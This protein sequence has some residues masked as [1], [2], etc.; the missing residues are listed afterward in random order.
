MQ[1]T[2]GMTEVLSA[3]QPIEAPALLRCGIDLNVASADEICA[4]IDGVGR[5]LG[6]AIVRDREIFGPFLTLRDLARVQGVGPR[7]FTRITGLAWRADG[8]AQREK[9]LEI[10]SPS[11]DGDIDLP[12]VARRF[13]SMKGFAGCLISDPDGHIVACSWADEK[14]EAL[15]AVAPHFIKKI[16]K[17]LPLIGAGEIDAMTIFV[18]ERALTMIP[19]AHLVMVL[20]QDANQFS[21]SQLRMAQQVV[22][23]ITQ[24]LFRD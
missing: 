8:V 10:L 2:I 17:Y 1:D 9:V 20:I 5:S 24:I 15:A 7:N 23:T 19:F 18:N 16:S 6:S 11:E 14:N 4:R 13:S 3:P 22:D 21:R 12:S